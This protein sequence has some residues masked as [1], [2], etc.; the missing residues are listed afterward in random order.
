MKRFAVALFILLPLSIANAYG[1]I[2]GTSLGEFSSCDYY[3]IE[4]SSGS[5]TLAEWY[6]GSTAY[7]GNVLVGEL[8]SYGFKDLY[9]ITRDTNTRV[10]IE[11]YLLSEDSA[12]EKLI[13]ECGYDREIST[14]FDGGGYSYTPTYTTPTY[15][16]PPPTTPTCPINSSLASNGQCNCNVGYIVNPTKT[17][18][19]PAPTCSS[20]YVL[21]SNNQCITNTQACRNVNNNDSNIIAT[22]GSDGKIGC[23]CIG[24]YS[25][26]GNACIS[27]PVPTPTTTNSSNDIEKNT[28]ICQDKLG[29]YGTSLGVMKTPTEPYCGCA[30]GYHLSDNLLSCVANVKTEVPTPTKTSETKTEDKKNINLFSDIKVGKKEE[31]KVEEKIDTSTTSRDSFVPYEVSTTTPKENWIKRVW[32]FLWR[33]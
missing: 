29:K 4:D 27:N 22:T 30:N 6:G 32:H 21:D 19:V 13:D 31:T 8:H 33:F 26:N 18:C 17:A 15:S 12:A 1:S 14:Y 23:N 11:D 20:G 10:W 16:P 5:Y 25:W 7:E 3:L 28:K 2:K 9:N 24:G